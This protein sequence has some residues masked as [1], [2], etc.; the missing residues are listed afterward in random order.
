MVLIQLTLV[1]LTNERL[2]MMMKKTSI[3]CY[4]GEG[5]NEGELNNAA[6]GQGGQA[7][8]EGQEGQEGQAGQAGQA[9]QE[10]KTFTQEELNK[11]L[12]DD[13]RKHQEKYKQLEDSYKELLQN[14][15]LT[16][17]ERDKMKSRLDDLQKS[18][19]TKE[20]QIEY[21]KKK[22]QEEWEEKLKEENERAD[23]WENMFKKET[24]DR[25]LQDAAMG[26]DAFNP[27]QIVSLLRPYTQ[28]KDDE[29][30][31]SLKAMVDFPDIDEKTGEPVNTLRTPQDAVKRMRELPKMYGNLFKSNVVSGVGA[32]N[33]S[34]TGDLDSMDYSKLTPEQYR[35]NRD[36]I[37][38][39]LS[40]N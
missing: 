12:A 6:G 27:N 29:E 30:S 37:K 20:Q 25:S 14:Q 4:E 40:G 18:Y 3:L 33:A 1:G 17:D 13:K 11:I 22:A 21:E 34:G 24:M 8:Q 7:G 39:R 15:N 2:G 38:K 23:K 36:Q 31:G 26:T 5:F 32:G 35:K 16:Q 9:G 19:R 10:G 28:L